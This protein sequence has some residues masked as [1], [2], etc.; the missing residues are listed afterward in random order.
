MDWICFRL[1]RTVLQAENEDCGY[2]VT[3]SDNV[4]AV[5][6]QCCFGSIVDV[7]SFILYIH[8]SLFKFC[9]PTRLR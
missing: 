3:S 1:A 7:A 2:L 8:I 5:V 6:Y 9:S 4:F